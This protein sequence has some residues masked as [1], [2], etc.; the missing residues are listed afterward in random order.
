MF[1]PAECVNYVAASGYDLDLIKPILARTGRCA[2][3][4]KGRA[5]PG[6][7]GLDWLSCESASCAAYSAALTAALGTGAC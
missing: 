6:L 5:G 7:F 3:N 1:P 4:E 2:E